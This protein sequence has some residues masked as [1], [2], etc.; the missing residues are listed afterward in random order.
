MTG[1][2]SRAVDHGDRL[3]EMQGRLKDAT[4]SGRTVIDHY[5]FD[6][7]HV[8]VIAPFGVQ[9]G[10]SL[11]FE[12]RGTVTTETYDSSGALLDTRTSPF[13][14]TFAVRRPTGDRWM[15][16]AVLPEGAVSSS[17]TPGTS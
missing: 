6:S 7:V 4:A 13:E 8:V 5:R 12:L 10:G 2:C 15:I 16:V 11:G 9:T 14:R 17:T 1:A 3:A